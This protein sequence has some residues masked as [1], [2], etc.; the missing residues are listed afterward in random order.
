M[1]WSPHTPAG[2][3]LRT[4]IAYSD[5]E[6]TRKAYSA[7]P[8]QSRLGGRAHSSCAGP[9]L[10]LG[11]PSMRR[12]TRFHATA[13]LRLPMSLVKLRNTVSTALIM[14]LV[15]HAAPMAYA[16]AS[17]SWPRTAP[18]D[19]GGVR[20]SAY[21]DPSTAPLYPGGVAVMAAPPLVGGAL[22]PDRDGRGDSGALGPAALGAAAAPPPPLIGGAL[23]PDCDARGEGG[24]PGPATLAGVPAGGGAPGPAALGVPPPAP[25]LVGVPAGDAAV[26]GCGGGEAGLRAAPRRRGAGAA[27]LGGAASAAAGA[28]RRAARPARAVA[29]GGAGPAA[30]SAPLPAAS[31]DA[32]ERGPGTS[33]GAGASPRG[34]LGPGPRPAA[35]ALA[36]RPAAVCSRS[37]SLLSR[38]S[39]RHFREAS[40]RAR[41]ARHACLSARACVQGL[42]AGAGAAAGTGAHVPAGMPRASGA[43]PPARPAA[44]AAGGRAAAALAACSLLG[45]RA[46][47]QAGVRQLEAPG[48]N[49]ATTGDAAAASRRGAPGEY[50]WSTRS[51]ARHEGCG[52]VAST[53]PVTA[54]KKEHSC[55]SAQHWLLLVITMEMQPAPPGRRARAC[56]LP[57]PGYTACGSAWR[58][59]HAR[60]RLRHG[61]DSYSVAGS[62]AHRVFARLRAAPA[63]ASR[64]ALR[65]SGDALGVS[66]C[67]LRLPAAALPARAARLLIAASRSLCHPPG[68]LA[69]RAGVRR[70][71]EVP[72]C[73]E[74]GLTGLRFCRPPD[75]N[76]AEREKLRKQLRSA[77]AAAARAPACV[78]PG[79]GLTAWGCFGGTHKKSH[80]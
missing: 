17:D 53:T 1:V 7:T 15:S 70:E 77:Q 78:R 23:P 19:S 68:V 24:A 59:P 20:T 2:R 41:P 72:T 66:G 27:T 6:S 58:R 80:G 36:A 21:S 13:L 75:R 61:I 12:R 22:V 45:L 47:G 44:R 33:A 11:R 10:G 60:P 28:R 40:L 65:F 76:D 46:P 74:P 56:A 9:G 49:A 67:V 62:R 57:V 42:L 26:G 29:L 55:R 73:A 14:G 38:W 3:G 79:P 34:A 30:A 4:Q 51:S 37:A 39:L 64:A 69:G 71:G 43:A 50:S 16:S 35:A 32:P 8:G 18:V 48:C 54:G 5:T 63:P 52:A 31:P 25:L